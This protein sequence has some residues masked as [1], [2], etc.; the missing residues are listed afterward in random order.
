MVTRDQNIT[1]VPLSRP[2][3]GEDEALAAAEVIRSGWLIAGP[4][5]EEFEQ[6]FAQVA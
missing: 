5:V 4:R 3:V 2:W 1:S 6:R